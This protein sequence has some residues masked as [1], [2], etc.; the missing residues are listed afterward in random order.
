[1]SV[2]ASCGTENPEIARFCLA[3]GTPI[4]APEPEPEVDEERRPV[5][6]VFVDMVGSTSRAEQLDPED[7]LAL[8]EPY[9]ARLRRDLEH[10]GGIV[11]KFIGDAVVAL[12]GA[13][14]A[15][16]DDPERAVRAGLAI[17]GSIEELNAEDPLR[18]L[19]VRVGITTGEAIVALAAKVAE[20]RGMAW[21]DVLNTA[22]RLQ[23]A[24][25]VN[26]VLVDERTYR[27]CDGAI[28]F[29]PH[30]PVEAKGKAEPVPV[31]EAVRVAERRALAPR[32]KLIGRDEEL[33][34]LTALSD[35]VRADR[36]PAL[37]LVLGEPG[38]G[39]SRL[40]AEVCAR[41]D[42]SPALGGRG[43]SYGEG[44]TYW[45]VL[46]MVSQSAGILVSD[47]SD[48]VAEKLGALLERLPTDDADQLRTMA[49]A[50]SN[51]LGAPT[52]PRGTYTAAE[53]SQSELHWGLRR[54]LELLATERPLALV[55]EDLHWA[56]PTLLELIEA[57]VQA[58]APILLLASARRE[59]VEQ[60]PE[61]LL[62][63][64]RRAVIELRELDEADSEVL[65]AE[66]VETTRLGR[67]TIERL[68][69]NAG[70]NPLFL[71]ETARMLQAAGED[72]DVDS[73]RVPDSLHALV[74]ARLDALPA[75]EKRLAQRSSVAGLV[76]WTGAA[77]CLDEA[78]TD[79]DGVL[80]ALEH[81]DVVH[82]QD[83]SSIA[84]ER[85]WE[86]K[87]A[88]IREV[89]YA[90]LPKG[91]RVGL[92][93]RFADW[94]ADL[95]SADEFIEIVAH[96]LEQACLI[97]R[98]VGRLDVEPPVERA[99]DLL[100]RA[101]EKAE[102]REG[103]REASR[104]YSRALELLPPDEEE[105]RLELELRRA[106]C[107]V[108]LGELASATDVLADVADRASGLGRRDVR[109][110]ALVALGNVDWK[111]GRAGDARP[112]LEE[113]GAIAR[114]IGDRQL[115]VRV[116][117][118]LANILGWFDGELE[119]AIDVL[120]GALRST[121]GLDN[122]PLQI[123]AHMRV[124]AL[125]SNNGE[126]AAA[127]THYEAA[128]ALARKTA[129]LRDEARSTTLLAG[130]WLYRRANDE[131]ERLAAQSLE[132]LERL[133]DSHLQLQTLRLLALLAL[134]RGDGR[135]AETW[136]RRAL[137]LVLD[138]GGWLLAE[139]F[140]LLVAALLAQDKHAEA[141]EI[142]TEGLEL[143]TDDIPYAR[144][145]GLLMEAAM[146]TADQ[147]DSAIA[148]FEAAMAILEEDKL[149]TDLGDAQLTQARALRDLGDLTGANSAFSAARATYARIGA[150]QLLAAIDRE[151][152]SQAPTG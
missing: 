127:E 17:L 146:K 113:A 28:E 152:V 24:A 77:A 33:A 147:D 78:Q 86:F 129:S 140:R 46:E 88:V 37:G 21:G 96:H 45:P 43:L 149:W 131:S 125:L 107:L 20:G 4:E 144:A 80:E 62:E 84:D 121:Q 119:A 31:W 30:P 91:R 57:L 18:E 12:F 118:E 130:V 23:S 48:V 132:W 110:A 142:A 145:A 109:C 120:Q 16:E 75:P 73:L 8:L 138:H 112:H 122:P 134:D 126:L 50:L 136:V 25:P 42:C 22:A 53:I 14:V 71:E 15:H 104:F 108:T 101:A 148:S 66:L 106:T 47:G 51:L 54:V 92:H 60:S 55:F 97:G 41:A 2:C 5:T 32:R 58:D 151:L 81:H 10:H 63:D 135:A 89:A 102:R 115:Q 44:I 82:E 19:R 94:I 59:L 49:A 29:R 99:V 139:I 26:G 74:G 100:A 95:K 93:V 103:T 117:F 39:K 85:E 70:G 79:P 124:G 83:G 65:V 56:E 40:L 9:Y 111:Q 35:W 67:E 68:V 38:L 141:R 114:E 34:Q 133:G 128:R 116:A 3:C 36:R 87:H 27:S 105:R 137:P 76:F 90:R 98:E 150:T 143:V 69:R 1:M 13:P 72:A 61:L 64:E 52:T 11:E 7:V 123:E 6:A